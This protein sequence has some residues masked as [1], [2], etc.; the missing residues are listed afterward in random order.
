MGNRLLLTAGLILATSSA[1]ANIIFQDN[2]NDG[3]AAGWSAI[4]NNATLWDVGTIGSETTLQSSLSQTAHSGPG[5][6]LIDGI[7]TTSHFSIEAD[8]R[9]VG[10]ATNAG[11]NW[12]HV[13]F[14]WGVDDMSNFSTSYLRTHSDQV[15]A[16]S[17]P[18]S[19]GEEKITHLGFNALNDVT[20][21]MALEVDY[22]NQIMTISLNS[23]SQ[24]FSGAD[25]L[26]VNTTG[27][28]SH[29]GIGMMTWGERVSYDNVVVRD[30][31][32][33]VPA[34]APLALLTAGLIGLGLSRRKAA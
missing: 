4:G 10:Q 21:H 7:G 8:V 20:Y 23:V 26:S 24:T 22:I 6:N 3:D 28:G 27:F 5:I 13:G 14:A 33:P 9:V 17:S 19:S 1:Q 2:F 25:F 32:N 16:W 11:A 18:Y 15:T 29:L 30:F 12:G 34:P 31:S